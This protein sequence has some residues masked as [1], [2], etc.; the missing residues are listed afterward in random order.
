MHAA[1][2]NAFLGV[3]LMQRSAGGRGCRIVRERVKTG[4]LGQLSL[5][6]LTLSRLIPIGLAQVLAVIIFSG[7][8]EIPSRK[9]FR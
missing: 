6:R 3:G 7:C 4:A 9:M 8:C 5:A 1:M 2:C